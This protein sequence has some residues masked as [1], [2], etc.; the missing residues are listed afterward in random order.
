MLK[1]AKILS[2]IILIYAAEVDLF[3]KNR[4]FVPLQQFYIDL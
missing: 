4:S 3:F 1:F 2:K